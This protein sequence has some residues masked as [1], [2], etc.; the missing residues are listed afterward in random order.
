MFKLRKSISIQLLALSI[1][2]NV[3]LLITKYLTST[4]TPTDEDLS[5]L[6]EMTVK[7]IESA[8][9]EKI[10]QEDTVI[11]IKPTVS[12]FNV[13]DADHFTVYE[14]LVKTEKQTYIFTCNDA[15]CSK[16]ENGGWTYSR[17]SEEPPILGGK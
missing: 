7:V 17:Y 12:R 4:Y 15:Q 5:L 6:A 10:A 11:A 8:D 1:A 2:L 14:I 9:Y 3:F 16:I 13:I